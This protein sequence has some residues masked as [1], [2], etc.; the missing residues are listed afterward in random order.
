MFHRD[1]G[2]KY[3]LYKTIVNKMHSASLLNGEERRTAVLLP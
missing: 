2:I 3:I 1:E